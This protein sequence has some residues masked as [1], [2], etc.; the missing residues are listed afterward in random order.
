M[1]PQIEE[2]RINPCTHCG[3]FG[4]GE[5]Q[6]L[7]SLDGNLS[8][9][10]PPSAAVGL[11]F[12]SLGGRPVANANIVENLGLRDPATGLLQSQKGQSGWLLLLRVVVVRA[13]R[14]RARALRSAS[15]TCLTPRPGPWT[16]PSDSFRRGDTVKSLPMRSINCGY[17]APVLNLMFGLLRT[18]AV[19][20]HP[21]R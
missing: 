13:L 10:I 8:G 3:R 17:C 18:Y 6:T 11:G 15:C 1:L 5:Q 7:L 16:P 21:R 20:D 9:D 14:S 4:N 19:C 12:L 2:C